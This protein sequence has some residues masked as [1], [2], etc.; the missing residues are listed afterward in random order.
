VN[1]RDLIPYFKDHRPFAI[2]ASVAL[3]LL[4][5]EEGWA[6][7]LLWSNR[8]ASEAAPIIGALTLIVLIGYLL[9]FLLPPRL[10]NAKWKYPRAWGV[11]SRV[12]TLSFAFAIATN[13]AAFALLLFLAGGN[14]IATY[15]LLR[16]VYI[17]TLVGL[18]I[19]HGLL[20]YVRYLRYVY[21]TFGAPPPSKV[22]GASAGIAIL[23][24]LLVGFLFS[25]D[26]RQLETASLAQQGLVGLHIYGR[27]FYL[28]TIMLG[29][30]AWHLRWVA[31]H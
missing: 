10:I 14:L 3:A 6:V 26:L 15:L 20:L 30:F 18:V 23:I 11:F 21:H 5:L 2:A 28:L 1:P 29:A 4:Y 19:F 13:V 16:D 17:Y 12:T 8:P 24:L 9:S 7:F 22:I 25:T 31:D 27:M